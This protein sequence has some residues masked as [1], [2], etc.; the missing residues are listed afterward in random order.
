MIQFSL[1]PL[2]PFLDLKEPDFFVPDLDH[3]RCWFGKVEKLCRFCL[4][5]PEG[6][7]IERSC[8]MLDVLYQFEDFRQPAWFQD[9]NMMNEIGTQLLYQPI[10]SIYYVVPVGDILGRLPLIPALEG[11][12]PQFLEG[13]R[14][15]RSNAPAGRIL[16]S[17][18]FFINSWAMLWPGDFSKDSCETE[19]QR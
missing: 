6:D 4:R 11:V 7:K 2:R 19:S 15:T 16:E 14:I 5:N 9:P 10:P 13:Q 8:A 1:P 12:V 17:A 3:D 18:F